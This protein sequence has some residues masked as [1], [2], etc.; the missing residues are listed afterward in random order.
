MSTVL[1][2]DASVRT[3]SVSIQSLTISSKQVTLSVFRQIELDTLIDP[4]T[5]KLNG[6]PWGRVNYYWKDNDEGLH[7]LWQKGSELRRDLVGTRPSSKL[8]KLIADT[9]DSL[10]KAFENY[11]L[12]RMVS[13]SPLHITGDGYSSYGSLQALFR[14]TDGRVRTIAMYPEKSIRT[15]LAD[16]SDPSEYSVKQAQRLIDQG[17]HDYDTAW[18]T[19]AETEA[20]LTRL[21]R[22]QDALRASWQ[23]QRDAL[24][25][26]PQLFI[27]V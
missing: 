16:S 9:S 18:A 12:C 15:T 19:V 7:V 5:A 26:L 27:A 3:A 24:G 14:F 11:A 10:S 17:I 21:E 23:R 6:L 22:E 13:D 25:E 2:K 4:E 20:E 1:T 8:D